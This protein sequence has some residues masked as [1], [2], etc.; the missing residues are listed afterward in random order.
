MRSNVFYP[1]NCNQRH[2][3]YYSVIVIQTCRSI[4]IDVLCIKH[5]N[6]KSTM[7]VTSQIF[8]VFCLVLTSVDTRSFNNL[9]IF[10]SQLTLKT[11]LIKR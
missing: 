10:Q 4:T 3:C 11:A 5:E 9:K 8:L 1:Y 7:F 6:Y 2:V